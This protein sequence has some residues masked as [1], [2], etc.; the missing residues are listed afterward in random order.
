MN[1]M[2]LTGVRVLE[3]CTG[4]VGPVLGKNLADFGAEVLRVESRRRLDFQRGHGPG[5]EN[6]GISF[7]DCSRNKLGLEIDLTKPE[8]HRLGIELVNLCDIFIENLG[9]GVMK[10]LCM[11]WETV[12]QVNPSL[13]MIS[14][15]GLG[16]TEPHSITFGQNLPP[17]IGLTHLWNH[18][19]APEPVG[20]QIFHPDYFAGVYC[21]SAAVAA[22]DY[23]RRT[24]EGCY[25]DIAQAECAAALLGPWYLEAAVNGR[26]P[27]PQ[28]N[29]SPSAAPQGVY[30]CAGEDA[31]CAIAV[32][33]DAQWEALAGILGTDWARDDRFATSLGR[34]R[35]HDELDR[36]LEEWTGQRSKHEVMELLQAAGVPAGAVQNSAEVHDDPHL[37]E[38]GF[39]S[40]LHHAEMGDVAAGGLAARLSGTPGQLRRA[41][42]LLGEHTEH[43]LTDLLGLSAAEIAQLDA[44]GVFY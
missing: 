42:P 24:G 8:G 41:A 40:T 10:R 1:E 14:M 38:R 25:L 11:D 2:P 16:A 15:Q 12:S 21:T 30:R 17:I 35:H 44:A 7:F 31:W 36:R 13:V 28:G 9:G 23:R 34:R 29:R 5:L 43:V 4:Y 19:G 39:L 33:T 3:I 37:E 26:P 18:P 20:S 22:L 32:E 27:Q 6:K